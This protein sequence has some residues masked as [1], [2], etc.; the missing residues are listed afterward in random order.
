MPARAPAP[1]P[2][3]SR[4][5]LDAPGNGFFGRQPAIEEDGAVL[6]QAIDPP[7]IDQFACPPPSRSRFMVRAASPLR[8]GVTW[9]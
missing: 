5:G 7:D 8:P 9:Q 4:V 2:L 6:L 3:V 1:R